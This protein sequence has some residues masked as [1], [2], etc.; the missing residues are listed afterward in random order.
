M[1]AEYFPKSQRAFIGARRKN[2]RETPFFFNSISDEAQLIIIDDCDADFDYSFFYPIE[3]T[4]ACGSNLKF[5]IKVER[6]GEWPS[7][8]H[9][10]YL[11]FTTLT[12]DPKWLKSLSFTA[13][14]DVIEFP[15]DKPN[16]PF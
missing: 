8:F 7:L 9:I 10:P 11:I 4:G 1:I 14:F 12:L 15:L 5:K 3:D 6:L 13:R 16:L 2:I